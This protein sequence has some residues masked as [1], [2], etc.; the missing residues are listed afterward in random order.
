MKRTEKNFL[1]IREAQ[2]EFHSILIGDKEWRWSE[3]SFW[4]YNFNGKLLFMVSEA[5]E[6]ILES[7]RGRVV[8]EQGTWDIFEQNFFKNICLLLW[9]HQWNND[10]HDFTKERSN[11]FPL[12]VTP[13][14]KAST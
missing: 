2:N 12:T 7:L 6:Y 1:N 3:I 11:M 14:L 4:I 10:C 5:M 8:M 13:K 9:R